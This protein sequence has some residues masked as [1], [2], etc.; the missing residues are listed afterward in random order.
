MVDI[1]KISI[2][3]HGSDFH[4]TEKT[5]QYFNKYEKDQSLY[6]NKVFLNNVN[7][8]LI[9]K[10]KKQ[11]LHAEKSNQ[12]ID[13]IFRSEIGHLGYEK[14]LKLTFSVPKILTGSHN[15]I[16]VNK[17]QFLVV[18][19]NAEK[20]LKN[21]GIIP[22]MMNGI[23]SIIEL[24]KDILSDYKQMFLYEPVFKAL[25]LEGYK[26]YSSESHYDYR[27]YFTGISTGNYR[28]LYFK[29]Y[30]KGIESNTGELNR[31][32]CELKIT[33]KRCVKKVLN[34]ITTMAGLIQG[35][36]EL[37]KYYIKWLQENIF[38]DKGNPI[39]N[40]NLRI[41]NS[42]EICKEFKKIFGKRGLQKF[43]SFMGFKSMYKTLGNDVALKNFLMD[44]LGYN[45]SY[46]RTKTN[47]FLKYYNR[48]IEAKNDQ[49]TV[50]QLY[51]EIKQKLFDKNYIIPDFINNP[52]E[53]LKEGSVKFPI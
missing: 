53:N 44:E 34:G 52:L 29:I 16:T 10:N 26:I 9:M 51:H 3:W 45:H 12:S 22:N 39:N 35:Y 4:E 23:I 24:K 42:T 2:F 46:A 27:G 21:I 36:D 40:N 17:D 19:Q 33:S 25:K 31:W 41:N 7:N 8:N 32:R 50:S 47:E 37:E 11:F 20:Y 43:S 18:I 1:D 6:G 48:F 15:M 13:K 28:T 49:P 14:Y 30:N 38:K 5:I